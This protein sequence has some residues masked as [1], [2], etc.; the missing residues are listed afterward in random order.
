MWAEDNPSAQREGE[1][2]G[3]SLQRT[4]LP[5]GAAR[6][7]VSVGLCPRRTQSAQSPRQ[8]WRP[9]RLPS[10]HEDVV[11]L[12]LPASRSP[13]EWTGGGARAWQPAAARGRRQM[14][15]ASRPLFSRAL[16]LR[17]GTGWFRVGLPTRRPDPDGVKA[18]TPALTEETRVPVVQAGGAGSSRTPQMAG[19]GGLVEG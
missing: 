15:K 14:R 11:C 12:R 1:H 7:P 17:P 16:L 9:P 10:Q 3:V 6:G 8:A 13:R 18:A 19:F 2:P 5:F 4:A